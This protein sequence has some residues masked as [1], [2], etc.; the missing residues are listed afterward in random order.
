[1]ATACKQASVDLQRARHNIVVEM[2]RADGRTLQSCITEYP[3]R[4]GGGVINPSR[5]NMKPTTRC[6]V[7]EFLVFKEV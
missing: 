2:E 4:G 7:S 1:M 6:R 5:Q 3:M